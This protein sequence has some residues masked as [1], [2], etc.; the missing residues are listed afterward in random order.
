MFEQKI[1]ES[2]VR[3][4]GNLPDFI[5]ALSSDSLPDA[6]KSLRIEPLVLV[7]TTLQGQDFMSPLMQVLT[8]V[9]GGYILQAFAI[10]STIGDIAISRYVDRVNPK[11]SPLNSLVGTV[12]D[13]S[14]I[15]LESYQYR[16]PRYDEPYNVGMEA[17]EYGA[18]KGG[19]V[20][21]NVTKDAINQMR[22]IEQLAVGK[23]LE[24]T[25][26][27]NGQSA[28]VPMLVR[29]APIGITPSV[30][31][32]VFSLDGYKNTY[33]ERWHRWRSGELRLVQDMI[34]CNDLIDQHKA[35][36]RQDTRGFYRQVLKNRSGNK[37]SA[38]FSG[39][40]SINSASNVAII[41]SETVAEIEVELGGSIENP[42]VREKIFSTSSLMLL[43]VVDT[44]WD[45]VWIYHRG[46][47]KPSELRVADLKPLTKNGGPD[48]SEILA[49]LLESKPPVY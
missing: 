33:K 25:I 2:L 24:V 28:T 26:T 38:I 37:L 13:A 1:G 36:L 47:D 48:V 30:L 7:D 21:R 4:L 5:N 29:L 31:N 35:A 15:G 9:Y 23:M 45:R 16:L 32:T 10:N 42:G 17:G 46:V 34:F 12:V 20:T 18:S 40:P 6:T 19:G 22:D 44:Q 49:R 8:N 41:N 11:R 27:H 3:A 14:R 43:V 39:T